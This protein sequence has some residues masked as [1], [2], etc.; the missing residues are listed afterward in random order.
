ML[1]DTVSQ[2]IRKGR[3]FK[4]IFRDFKKTGTIESTVPV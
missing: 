4:S 1:G 3:V 2:T